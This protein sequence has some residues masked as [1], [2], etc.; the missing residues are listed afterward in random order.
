MSKSDVVKF[1][2]GLLAK[3]K[4]IEHEK[5]CLQEQVKN[6]SSTEK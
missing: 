2:I 1:C 3:I 5:T 4:D 6:F